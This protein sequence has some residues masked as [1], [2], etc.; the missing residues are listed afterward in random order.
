MAP[1]RANKRVSGDSP[2]QHATSPDRHMIPTKTAATPIRKSPIKKRKGITLEQK[3][4]LI[5]NLQL[6][7]TDRARRL[8]AQ[9]H[10]QAQ[11]LRSR[12]EMRVNRIP[13]SLLK[14]TMQDLVAKC[15]EQQKKLAAAARPPP[16]PEKDFPPRASPVKTV[17]ASQPAS[18]PRKRLSEDMAGDKENQGIDNP[19]KK[20]RGGPAHISTIPEAAQILSPTSTNARYLP[21]ERTMASPAKPAFSRPASPT[22]APTTARK[23]PQVRPATRTGRRVSESSDGSTATVVKKPAAAKATAATGAKRTVMGTIRKGVAASTAKKAAATATAAA[24][25]SKA[26]AASTAG[27]TRVL[28]KRG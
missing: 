6:E 23:P 19:K 3:Q 10:A 27:S 24:A 13:R 14:S 2:A 20:H 21:R 28:R 18:R 25:A 9:Y 15:A 12:V 11:S 26:T 16:V 17:N 8:R 1:V 5:E 22:K 7:I 4:A